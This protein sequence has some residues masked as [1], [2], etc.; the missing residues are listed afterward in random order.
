MVVNTKNI[1]KSRMA[2]GDVVENMP[3]PR[4]EDMKVLFGS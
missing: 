3:K 1:K 4:E 2:A